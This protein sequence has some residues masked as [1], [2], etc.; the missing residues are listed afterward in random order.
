MPHRQILAVTNQKGGVGKTTTVANLGAA[1]ADGG[2]RV[3]LVD[4]DPQCS[5]T[6]S[7][8]LRP[9]E[10][11]RSSCELLADPDAEPR[12]A[13][14]A[15]DGEGGALDLVPASRR[16]GDLE[17]R[18]AQATAKELYLREALASVVGEYAVVLVDTPPNLGVLTI[19]ALAAADGVL[20]PL[21][22][23]FLPL[24][25]LGDLDA[26]IALLRRYRI[27][28]E[29]TIVGVIA[30]MATRRLVLEREVL[31]AAAALD[32]PLLNTRI[33]RS[34]RFAE[35]PAHGRPLVRWLPDHPG[36]AAYRR[37]AEEVQGVRLAA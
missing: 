20:V 7:F 11:A 34:V 24:Q 22:P 4:L 25:G 19:N 2:S 10:V 5:L 35:A 31:E 23:E 12:G 32:V 36:A 14:V 37:L 6:L 30:T 16:L 1:L 26:T 18:L 3:L 8:G 27:N 15:L 29:L 9:S 21:Q 33:P 13:I 28:P 17:P